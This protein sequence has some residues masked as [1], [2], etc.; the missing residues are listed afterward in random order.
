MLSF[1]KEL[2][3][4]VIEELTNLV[5]HDEFHRSW[6]IETWNLIVVVKVFSRTIFTCKSRNKD[7]DVLVIKTYIPGL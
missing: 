2:S 7:P 4:L 6:F 1:P 3:T 5:R